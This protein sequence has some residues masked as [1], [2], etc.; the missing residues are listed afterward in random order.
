M[1]GSEEA[2]K[3]SAI[4]GE[5]FRFS[6]YEMRNGSI[7]PAPKARFRTYDPWGLDDRPYR[8]LSL[9]FDIPEPWQMS[10]HRPEVVEAVLEWCNQFGLLG[11]LLHRLVAVTYAHRWERQPVKG[12]KGRVFAIATQAT[13]WP[14]PLAWNTRTIGSTMAEG[15]DLIGAT[16]PADKLPDDAIEPHVL[17]RDIPGSSRPGPPIRDEPL[18]ETWGKYFP[19]VPRSQWMSFDYPTP[20]SKKFWAAYGEPVAEFVLGAYSLM[21]AL[22]AILQPKN[23]LAVPLGT[24]RLTDLSVCAH[25]ILDIGEDSARRQRWASSSLLS[26]LALMAMEDLTEDV[27]HKCA[28]CGTLFTATSYQAEYCSATCRQTMQ[29]RRYRQRKRQLNSAGKKPSGKGE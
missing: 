15:A 24:T 25:P 20:G 7:A 1:S 6:R 28:T 29:K 13:H 18:S 3:S 14:T 4:S 10:A 12:A 16:V 9:I 8:A 23:E 5:W 11:T 2:D 22:E 19:N 17:L 27:V 26:T 21:N